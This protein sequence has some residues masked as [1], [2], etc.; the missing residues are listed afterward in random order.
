MTKRKYKETPDPDEIEFEKTEFME[1]TLE[2]LR[3]RNVKTDGT[4]TRFANTAEIKVTKKKVKFYI[5]VDLRDFTRSLV[6]ITMKKERIAWKNEVFF[7]EKNLGFRLK[8]FLAIAK[9]IR[10]D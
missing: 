4:W 7:T 8:K 3:D 1:E 5:V 2:M 10:G 9:F 6:F